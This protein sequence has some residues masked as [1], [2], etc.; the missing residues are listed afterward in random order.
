MNQDRGDQISGRAIAV[1][2]VP[3]SRAIVGIQ[4]SSTSTTLLARTLRRGATLLHFNQTVIVAVHVI[5]PSPPKY[6][7]PVIPKK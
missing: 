5:Y 2:P 7:D 3:P 6:H 1:R 4:T